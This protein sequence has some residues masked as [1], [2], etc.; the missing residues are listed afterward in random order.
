MPKRKKPT[1]T[2]DLA[3]T[4]LAGC[5][6]IDENLDLGNGQTVAA[7]EAKINQVRSLLEAYNASLAVTE[8]NKNLFV[9]GEKELGDLNERMLD[10]VGFKFGKDSDEYEMAGGTRKSERKKPAKK[11]PPTT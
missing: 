4:R 11:T 10:G 6:S 2:M 1:R 9:A 5:K 8:Q 7:Y 3:D